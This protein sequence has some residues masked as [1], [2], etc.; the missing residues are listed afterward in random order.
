M[1]SETDHFCRLLFDTEGAGTYHA[2]AMDDLLRQRRTPHEA[3]ASGQVIEISGKISD[4]PELTKIVAADL[5]T[6]GGD[7]PSSDWRDRKVA[8]QLEFGFADA[9]GTIPAL[10]GR[11][12]ATIE[13]VCQRCL[14]PFE[15]PLQ[16]EFALAFADEQ[17]AAGEEYEVWE[18]A[19][20]ELS[21]AGIVEEILIMSIPFAPMHANDARCIET[22]E[23]LVAADEKTT[24]FANLKAQMERAKKNQ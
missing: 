3:A 2:R 10:K 21:P 14:E 6:L 13:A 18:L 24:P 4:F 17:S 1:N 8:G 11:V 19:D 9:Q 20:G 16:T 7:K 22:D 23:R 12:S 15:L 5:E